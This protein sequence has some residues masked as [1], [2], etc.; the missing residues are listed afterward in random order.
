SQNRKDFNNLLDVY[1]DAVF[2]SNLNELDF[3]QEGW[4]LEFAERSNPETP[5]EYKGVVYN[6]MKG[7][8]SSPV[9]VLWQTLTSDLF[10]T[11]TYHYNSGGEPEHIP[12]LT[13]EE[14]KAF[15]RKHYHPSNAVFMTYGNIPAVE[16]QK[17]FE[18]KAL[19]EFDA[20]GE[21]IDVTDEKRYQEPQVF[22]SVYAA[23][24]SDNGNR[25]H[26]VLAWLLGRSIDTMEALRTNLM[27]S[28]LLDNSASPLL[29]ALETTELGSAPSPMCGTEDSNREMAFMAGI[30][31]SRPEDAETL[32]A[33][34]L[35]TLKKVV[36]EGI[37]QERIDAALHQLELHQREV[38]GDGYPYGLQLILGG[39]STAIHRGDPVASLNLDVALEQLRKE[40]SE[41]DFIPDMIRRCLL[42][43]KHRIRLTMKPDT[44]LAASKEERE[45]ERLEAIRSS[46]D[47]SQIRQVIEMSEK[48]AE[49][50][51][52][53]DDPEV[54]PKVT[55]ADVPADIHIPQPARRGAGRVDATTYAQG[56]NGL[57]YQQVIMDLPALDPS[58]IE[59]L[60]R[61][62]QVVTELGVGDRSY[63][64]TQAWQ[65]AVSGGINVSTLVRAGLDD[66]Q[67]V[68]GKYVI[69]G[70]SLVRN[71]QK[72]TELIQETLLHPR[73]DEL[74][75]IRELIAQ[76]RIRS[77]NSVT[78]QGH[79]LAMRAAASGMSGRARMSHETRGLE[80]IRRLKALDDSLAEQE[81]LEQMA[82]ELADLHKILSGGKAS[83]LLIGE[84]EQLDPMQQDIERLWDGSLADT[85][86]SGFSLAPV[87]EQVNECWMTNTQVNFCGRAYPAVPTDHPDA[88]AF[89]VLGGFLRN[90]Y[91]HSRVRE[92]GG[93]YGGGASF[94]SDTG[95][96][97]FYSYRDPRL[98]ETLEDFDRSIEWLLSHP[99]EYRALEEAILG[100][101][102]SI[103]KP[104]SPAGEA[105]KAFY[106][107][108][109]G[110]DAEQRRAYRSKIL[111][112]TL[113][114][115][116]RVG[117]E[118]LKPER[119]STAVISHA[120]NQSE[121]ESL[122]LEIIHL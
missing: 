101:V 33:L 3:A 32:E 19:K 92:Q 82:A 53:E 43:N 24:E 94:D 22:E 38:K 31:G 29:H 71:H 69:S 47:D 61:Y 62:L 93:A 15:Y 34:V 55:L 12:E 66:V 4:R 100:V 27:T 45:R 14:L 21:V 75:K 74:P 120:A 11:T 63:V 105:Q 78:G 49:R 41:P 26:I 57:A 76:A 5:L 121:A 18:E 95:A 37:P 44:T 111:A 13:Y 87:T 46:M 28:V 81:N 108:M 118:W 85:A 6:E 90:G 96:F 40:A 70:K 58:R 104:G 65:D 88:P 20:L 114:D 103:D 109:F 99:H 39:L 86:S 16:L 79:V 59:L 83:F 8:M 56:T 35:D 48:L 97:R 102:S 106:G 50:Q 17:Q 116:K 36:E 110:R 10:P 73:F 1:L 107:E 23:D 84:Q 91:L 113:D 89:E 98:S 112:V 2:F 30:E 7:A 52:Q 122:G 115:L 25:T 9:S 119:A 64:E 72:L 60:P 68:Q 80:G 117:S 54:L 51:A 67:K 42:D 77:E